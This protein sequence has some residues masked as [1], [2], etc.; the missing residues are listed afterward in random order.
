MK[1]GVKSLTVRRHIMRGAT[2]RKKQK[3]AV[4]I[5]VL[6]LLLVMTVLAV[7]GVG[8]SV[9]EQKMSGNYYH[10]TTAFEAAEFG[11]RV[12]E[13]WLYDNVTDTSAFTTSTSS[14]GLYTTQDASTPNTVEV[15][16]GDINCQFDPRNE[17]N[18]CSGGAGCALPKGFA[19]LGGTLEGNTLDTFDMTVSRQPQFIIEYIGPVKESSVQVDA[20]DLSG[21]QQ[22]FRITVIGWGQEGVS[23]QVVQSHVLLTL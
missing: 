10:S 20:Y 21:E 4:L 15:C 1:H 9:L 14:D 23:R 11:L 8:N 2:T 18:W 5:I 19:T 7:S 6:M 16:G 12:A 17:A 22:A 13:Q 3:G